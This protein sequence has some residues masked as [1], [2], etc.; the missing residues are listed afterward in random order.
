MSMIKETG[1]KITIAIIVGAVTLGIVYLKD[2]YLEE[3]HEGEEALTEIVIEKYNSSEPENIVQDVVETDINKEI[4]QDNIEVVEDKP[5]E[6]I[7]QEDKP[8][9]II[10][11][12]K[13]YEEKT[14]EEFEKDMKFNGEQNSAFD[15]LDMEVN[16]K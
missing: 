9:D 7:I 10:K 3:G 15:E 2:N 5:Q 14:M 4:E 1:K 6:I 8:V 12:E 11:K 16:K 13:T